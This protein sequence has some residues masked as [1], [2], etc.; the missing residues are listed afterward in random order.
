MNHGVSKSSSCDPQGNDL[1]EKDD[2]GGKKMQ[3]K[4]LLKNYL[5]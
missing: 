1:Q 3:V 4:K 5:E 2:G